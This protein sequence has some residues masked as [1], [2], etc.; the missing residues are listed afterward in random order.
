MAIGDRWILIATSED[1]RQT[2]QKE[3]H[4]IQE[5]HVAVPVHVSTKAADG[6]RVVSNDDGDPGDGE[7]GGR[8]RSLTANRKSRGHSMESRPDQNQ[9]KDLHYVLSSQAARDNPR[10]HNGIPALRYIKLVIRKPA[11]QWGVSI[12]RFQVWGYEVDMNSSSQSAATSRQDPY[13][14]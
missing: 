8:Q 1:A 4:V 3:Y 9:D 11:T 2:A 14:T 13:S 6:D 10:D 12:W 7:G 5:V